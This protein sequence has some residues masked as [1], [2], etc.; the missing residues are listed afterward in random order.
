MFSKKQDVQVHT[1]F[2][3]GKNTLIEMINAAIEAG[4]G[5]ILISD[6]ARGWVSATGIKTEFFTT[7]EKYARISLAN[8]KGKKCLPKTSENIF[9]T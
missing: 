9:S 5:S 6:H 7:Y 1:I 3:D 8:R 2:S 4:I